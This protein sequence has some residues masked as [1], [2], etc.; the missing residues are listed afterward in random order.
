VSRD[1]A[2]RGQ[3]PDRRR[4]P[5]R[6]RSRG[7][8]RVPA[9]IRGSRLPARR[10]MPHRRKCAATCSG[11]SSRTAKP[12]RRCRCD[13]GARKFRDLLS[14]P[15]CRRGCVR[16]RNPEWPI[17]PAPNTG[18]GIRNARFDRSE[19]SSWAMVQPRASCRPVM[20]NRLCTPPSGDPPGRRMTGLPARARQRRGTRES[21]C[22][23][24]ACLRPRSMDLWRDCSRPPKVV[25]DN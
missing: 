13:S 18:V 3:N 24:P 17:R 22:A 12:F 23:R 9:E 15:R 21:D 14:R 19:K 11:L 25:N 20:T 7:P 10:Y 2:R 4:V 6:T 1:P 8:L 5:A 16:V